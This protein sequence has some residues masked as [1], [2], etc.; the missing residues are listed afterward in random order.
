MH[1]TSMTV[2][3][4]K[5]MRGP[6]REDRMR[7]EGNKDASRVLLLL[8][9]IVIGGCFG[10]T[11]RPISNFSPPARSRKI[12]LSRTIILGCP[13]G[14]RERAP[15]NYMPENIFRNPQRYIYTRPLRRDPSSPLLPP[16]PT[17]SEGGSY[18]ESDELLLRRY[19]C[20]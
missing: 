19:S 10:A 20:I 9:T 2:F 17:L 12:S 1:C 15:A 13:P 8:I 14:Q 7:E 18:R 11:R 16:R 5:F 6:E 3:E 4:D